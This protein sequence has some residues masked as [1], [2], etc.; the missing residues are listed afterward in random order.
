MPSKQSEAVRR[1]WTAARLAIV[2][3]DTE[4]AG[5]ESWG[6][7]T[8]EP[9]QVDYIE[10]EA[11]G[12]PAMWAVPKRSIEDRVLLCMHGGGY[13]SGTMYSHRKMFGHLAKATGVRALIFDYHLAPGHIHPSQVD[14]A[15]DVYRWL[16]DQGISA[17]HIAFTGDSAG[18][19]LS[20]TTQLRARQRGLPLPAAAMPFSPWVDMEVI[21]ASYETNRDRDPFFFA[22]SVRQFAGI[23][24]GEGGDPRDPLAN[25]LYAD[26]SGL[27]PIYIQVGADETLLDDARRLDE[28][29]R[30]AGV[31]VRLDVFP[32]MLHTFQ[33]AAGRAPEADEAVLR[34]ADWV[35]PRLG[36]SSGQDHI[37]T[38]A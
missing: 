17:D 25:P 13:I 8:A 5:D 6:D 21:G 2:Q 36:L 1:H 16:L 15:A 32:D 22:E 18:G 35:R 28:H 4:T 20:I 31:D 27:G 9:R 19:G 7:L 33:M 24:L 26:L 38:G 14:E 29:A 12:L 23:F 37:G 34:M 10:V 11:A 3:P 30:G